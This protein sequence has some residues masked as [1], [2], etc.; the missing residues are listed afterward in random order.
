MNCNYKDKVR[1]SSSKTHVIENIETKRLDDKKLDGT[2]KISIK[3][4][5]KRAES[6]LAYV[7]LVWVK[8]R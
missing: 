2:K 3:D 5:A 7:G 1:I 6:N 8:V 4:L